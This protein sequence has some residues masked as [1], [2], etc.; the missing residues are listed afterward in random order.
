MRGVRALDRVERG[1]AGCDMGDVELL[2]T[3]DADQRLADPIVVLDE[4]YRSLVHAR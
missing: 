2:R 3:Q 4:E 1:L